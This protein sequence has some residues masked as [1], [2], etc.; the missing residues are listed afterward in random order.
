MSE[1]LNECHCPA[2]GSGTRFGI[3]LTVAAGWLDSP[4]M[5]GCFPT[6]AIW[7]SC[8]RVPVRMLAASPDS[9]R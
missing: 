8:N 7:V 4:S 6:I 3:G 1:L 5:N 9:I 2:E